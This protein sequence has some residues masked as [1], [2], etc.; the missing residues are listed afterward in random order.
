M[1]LR[2][3]R[4]TALAASFLFVAGCGSTATTAPT[5]APPATPA[6]ATSA[7]AASVPA[8]SVPAASVAPSPSAPNIIGSYKPEPGTPGG[9]V[10]I[11]EWQSPGQINAYYAQAETDVEAG[12][13][14]LGENLV[15]VD[16][17]LGYIPDIATKVPVLG[18]GVTVNSDG[19]MDVEWLLKD[20][21]QWSDGQPITC[22][23]VEGTWKW[24]MDPA[25]TG[26]AAGTIGWEDITSVDKKSATDCVVHFKKVYEG[27]L[28]LWAPLLPWHYISKIPV[29]DATTKLYPLNDLTSGVYSGPFLPTKYVTDAQL[30]YIPN[31]KWA[32]ISGH[33]PYL[34]SLTFKYYGAAE[35]MIAGYKSGEIDFAMDLNDA[36]IPNLKDIDQAQVSINNSLTYELNAFNG[37]AFKKKFGDDATT[38][39]KAIMMATDR[40]QIANGPLQGNVSVTNNFVS[41]LAWYFKDEGQPKPADPAGA[42]ALLTGAGW[43]KGSDGYL[44]KNGKTLEVQYCSTT[45]Q[46]RID[47]LNLIASQLKAIGIKVDVA[48][49]PA[50]DVFGGWNDT[51]ADTL[52][53]TVHGNF[54]VAEFAYVAPIDPLGAY[55]VYHSSGIPDIAPHNGQNVTRTSIPAL[56]AAYDAVKNNVDPVKVA[57]AMAT[58]QDI[59]TSDQNTFELPLY[60]RKDVYLVSPKIHNFAPNPTTNQ[61]V[62]NMGDWWLSQ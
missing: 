27:Y 47:T 37:A 6:P 16:N 43:A 39:I 53:N 51:P 3:R 4:W 20:G 32:T 40:Q 49:K 21:A 24:V 25:Q 44:A 38:I 22:D 41:P 18:D 17:K 52:C 46:V 50:S 48:N 34:S 19:T 7:P 33:A 36:D 9:S 11:A 29:K 23:D 61:G 15:T 31:P 30:N 8:A 58:V 60:Y 14:S 13:P 2:T 28:T 10:V 54:D 59:Y 62:W 57:A 12:L 56:D 55:N 5:A 42:E 26:L 45:R 35:N 1:S